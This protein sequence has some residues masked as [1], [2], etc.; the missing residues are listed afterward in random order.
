MQQLSAIQSFEF[1]R[2]PIPARSIRTRSQDR[3]ISSCWPPPARPCGSNAAAMNTA[4]NPHREEREGARNECS[5]QREGSA[6]GTRMAAATARQGPV[7]LRRRRR[8]EGPSSNARSDPRDY[9]QVGWRLKLDRNVG[10]WRRRC[11]SALGT[12]H[13]SSAA[14]RP[15]ELLPCTRSNS[16]TLDDST[17]RSRPTRPRDC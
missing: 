13:A 4:K 1:H 12:N 15:A 2:P 14:A 7:S 16:N 6:V 10:V 9:A 17:Q 8:R 3:A 11:K 5:E